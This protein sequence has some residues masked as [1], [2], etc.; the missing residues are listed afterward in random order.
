VVD[1][2]A[3]V[4][5]VVA[6]G[7]GVAWGL[8]GASGLTGDAAF[9]VRVAG[10]VLG[11]LLVAAAVLR[12][13]GL[14]E[15]G[16]DE[17][18]GAESMFRSSAFRLITS[19][20]VVAIV[21]GN[22]ALQASGHGGYVPAWIAFVVGLHFLGFGRRFAPVFTVVGAAFL[23][24]AVVGALTGLAGGTRHGIV[25]GTGLIAAASLFVAGGWGLF[26]P[27]QDGA[28]NEASVGPPVN[29]RSPQD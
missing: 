21:A 26:P 6:A 28:R 10:G 1:R 24:A 13:R 27:S 15:S 2:E 8:W 23:A 18:D 25:G 19:A 5:V 16:P 20:E 17:G 14:P 29:R 3:L 4:G 7:F 11:V 12:W 9:V 22:A